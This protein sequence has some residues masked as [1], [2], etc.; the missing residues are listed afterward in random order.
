MIRGIRDHNL[1]VPSCVGMSVVHIYPGTI[2]NIGRRFPYHDNAKSV[3][4]NLDNSIVSVNPIQVH[5]FASTV[6]HIV[7]SLSRSLHG[8]TSVTL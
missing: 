2:S 1:L 3:L 7:P 4:R 8:I 6:S 5:G